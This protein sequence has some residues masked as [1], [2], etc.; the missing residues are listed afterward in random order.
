MS[1]APVVSIVTPFL[2]P[3]RFFEE[4]IASVFAQT[5][6]RW[7]LLL[8]DDGSTDGSADL[9]RQRAEDDPERVR[10]L[11][12][13]DRQNLGISASRNLALRHARGRYVA[14]L[15]ADDVYLPE[16]IARQV[17]ALDAQPRVG[18][19]YGGTEYWHQW[20]G[21]GSGEADWTWSHFGVTPGVVVAPPGPL[22]HYLRDG[23]TLPCMGGV[24]VRRDVLTS[25]GG[26]EDQFRGLFED[27]AFLAKICL[28]APVLVLSTCLDRYRQHAGSVCR[29]ASA[30]DVAAARAVYLRWLDSY[31]RSAANADA[32]VWQALHETEG[33]KEALNLA[34]APP[35]AAAGWFERWLRAGSIPMLVRAWRRGDGIVPPPGFV[36][37]GSLRRTS[38][39]SSVWGRDRGRSLDRYYIEGFLEKHQADVRGRVLEVGDA[40]YTRQFGGARVTRSD[41]LHVEEGRPGVTIVAD[42]AS[43]EH[44]PGNTFDCIILTQTLQLLYDV[45]AALRTLHRILA[46]GGVLL[47]TIPGITHTGDADWQRAWYWSFT[48]NSARRLFAEAFNAEHVEVTSYGNVLAAAAFL[49]GLADRELTR[50]E[51]DHHDPAYDVVVA[52]RA[53]KAGAAR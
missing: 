7:E 22:P 49:Y 2:N 50:R 21:S 32:N 36:R 37:F 13:P 5:D 51:L 41:V 12:H 47:V 40:A 3:G 15:D 9:A 46:P 53:T 17:P 20:E 6:T 10:Y 39:V 4:A 27:Q 31:M 16:K 33:A 8:V 19:V 43:A 34:A 45:P 35:V 44:V 24:L 38:P 52:I 26:F 18:M 30:A 48:T 1:T 28:A 29:S 14:F 11:Q 23:K 25:V 42:L